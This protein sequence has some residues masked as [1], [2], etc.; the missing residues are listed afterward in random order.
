MECTKVQALFMEA[1]IWAPSA[2]NS[3][4]LVFRVP[5][6][7]SFEVG[8]DRQLIGGFSDQ[9]GYLACLALGAA[10]QN[11]LEQA[12]HMGVEIDWDL[13]L[14]DDYAETSVCFK[15]GEEQMPARNDVYPLLLKRCTNRKVPFKSAPEEPCWKLLQE[16]LA[17][18]GTKL[19][20]FN[21]PRATERQE[22]IQLAGQAESLRFSFQ[23]IQQELCAAID[24]EDKFSGKRHLPLSALQLDPVAKGMLK[25][26][27]HWPVQRCFNLL[28]MQ[29]MLGF[30]GVELP[31]RRS[32]YLLALSAS[33]AKV[34]DLVN[35]GRG[36]Q[37][38]WLALTEWGL[39]VQ[40]YA[41]IGVL[42][43]MH[44]AL[45]DKL[46]QRQLRIA[47]GSRYLLDKRQPIMLFRVGAVDT[48][49]PRTGRRDRTEFN[50]SL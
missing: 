33:S 36:M 35:A 27:R 31:I 9:G 50:L 44:F 47:S 43:A 39:A 6:T 15:W 48:S 19:H 22:L 20:W 32:P 1:A 12:H 5:S 13:Q 2:D 10:V 14:S 42:S 4:P 38:L 25:L 18:T 41:A 46:Y 37:S 11:I 24:F 26:L 7:N 3:Q 29:R 45:P 16:R 17:E 30:M 8:L 28:G 40:P 34:D 49:P 21:D 23:E